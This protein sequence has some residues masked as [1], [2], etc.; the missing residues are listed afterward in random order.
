MTASYRVFIHVRH[1]RSDNHDTYLDVFPMLQKTKNATNRY[2]C[3]NN[4][5]IIRS[6]AWESRRFI[7]GLI[8]IPIDR[9]ICHYDNYYYDKTRWSR[10]FKQ[11]HFQLMRFTRIQIFF[12][13]P[14]KNSFHSYATLGYVHYS[15]LSPHRLTISCIRDS[16]KRNVYK[17]LQNVKHKTAIYEDCFT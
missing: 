13:R 11:R 17:V 2:T 8:I 16:V 9:N 6:N 3:D 1:K 5:H 14:T 7:L 12:E 15:V 4:L 10:N